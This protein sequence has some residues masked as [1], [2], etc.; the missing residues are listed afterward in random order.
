ME[1]ASDLTLEGLTARVVQ[2]SKLISDCIKQQ[3]LPAMSFD[4]DGPGSF[5]VPPAFP[6]VQAARFALIEA[7]DLLRKLA[8]GAKENV[9]ELACAVC[10]TLLASVLA[11]QR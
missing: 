11:K 6:D 10:K 2:S 5:P 3:N 1:P 7:S 8:L 4:V 9:E